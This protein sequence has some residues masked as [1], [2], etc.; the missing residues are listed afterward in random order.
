M[1]P[2]QIA[3][4][5][6]GTREVTGPADNPRIMA[7]YA[8]VGH[9]WVEHDEVAWCAAFVGHCLEKAGIRSTRQLNARSYL[10]FGEAVP[11]DKAREGDIAVFQRGSSSWQGH[12]AF[13]VKATASQIEVLGGNQSNGVTIAK[14]PRT[15][16][17]GI[18]RPI[19]VASNSKPLLSVVQQKLKDL[20]YHEVGTVDGKLGPRTRAAILAFK[21]DNGLPLSPEMDVAFTQALQKAPPREIAPERA[22][23]KPQGSR[24][25]GAANAQIATGLVGAVSVAGAVIAPA[26]EAAERAKDVTERAVGL[27]NLT[28]FIAPFLPWI[29]VA[30]LAVVIVLAWRA[31]SAR[32]E[33]FRTGKTP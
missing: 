10:T 2:F 33:D 7:M 31:R 5:Y 3:K 6:L 9:D 21:A 16:L 20:G 12:V 13:F 28:E 17:L 19:G 24:I 11:V 22:K 8:S 15:R 29:G 18:R 26:I 32:I 23:G 25:V 4:T 27:L 30:I 1:T 14:Y